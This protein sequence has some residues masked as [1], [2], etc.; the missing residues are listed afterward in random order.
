MRGYLSN[1]RKIYGL[2]VRKY[3]N[4]TINLFLKIGFLNVGILRFHELNLLKSQEI[5]LNLCYLMLLLKINLPFV[6]LAE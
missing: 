4:K 5:F 6:F 3:R 2:L 1:I